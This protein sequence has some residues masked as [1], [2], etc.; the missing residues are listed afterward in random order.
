MYWSAGIN[1]LQ[2]ALLMGFWL[3]LPLL[4]A[5]LAGGLIASLLQGALVQP[6]GASLVAPRLLAAGLAILFFGL[7]MITFMGDY[8]IALWVG[9]VSLIK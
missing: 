4:G 7:W 2:G 1:L 3:A 6:D 8:W 9:V 5:I